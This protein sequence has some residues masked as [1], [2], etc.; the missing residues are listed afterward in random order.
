MNIRHT[1]YTRQQPFQ[2][3]NKLLTTIDFSELEKKLY[4]GEC[5]ATTK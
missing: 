1:N 4:D 2:I 5:C 3:T